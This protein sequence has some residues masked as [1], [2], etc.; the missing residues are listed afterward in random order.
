MADDG[1]GPDALPEGWRGDW[2]GLRV[3][4]LGLDEEGFAAADTLAELGA[5]VLVVGETPDEDRERIL[6]V[7][8]VS[9]AIAPTAVGRA[10][11]AAGHA[12]ALFVASSAVPPADIA[13]AV[14]A[15][16]GAPLWG[17]ADLAWRLRDKVGAPAPWILVTGRSVAVTAVV[18]DLAARM[19]EEGELRVAPCGSGGV[20]VLD[21]IRD[22]EGFDVILVEV[23]PERLALLDAAVEPW[24]TACAGGADGYT[25][26][27][28]ARVYRNTRSACVYDRTDARTE[29]YVRDADV[30]EGARAVGVGLDAPGPSDLG[31]VDGI[32]CD[33]AFLAERA[34]SALELCTV[35]ELADSGRPH[36]GA[37]VGA[38]LFAAAL[39]RSVEVSAGAIHAVLTS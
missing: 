17:E 30:I 36:D 25:G 26:E 2:A 10:E 13:A 39:A 34:T 20:P 32:L 9:V 23:G 7:L 19:M 5:D 31:V 12:P 6:G 3:A 37:S 38:V 24:A 21:A 18:A 29:D 11:A 28:L 22:P 14:S 16:P 8:G 27:L 4:V 15:V 1:P 35:Q 33:R